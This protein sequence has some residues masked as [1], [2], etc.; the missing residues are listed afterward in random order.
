MVRAMAAA[1]VVDLLVAAM[2]A[3]AVAIA[4]V[5]VAAMPAAAARPSH[6]KTPAIHKAAANLQA[7]HATPMHKRR[8]SKVASHAMTSTTSSPPATRLPDSPLPANPPA[9]AATSVAAA[10]AAV[11]VALVAG[12]TGLVGRAVLARLLADKT[13]AAVHCVGRHPPAQQDPRRVA[14][15]VDS[16]SNFAAPPVDDVFIALGTT[17]KVAGSQPA[18]RAVDFDAVVAVA[19]AAK[20]AGATKLGVISAMGASTASAVFYNRVKGEMEDAID[21][22][23]YQALVIARPSMLAGDRD[24][25]AQA[26]RPAEKLGLLAMTLFKPLIPANYRAITATQVAHALLRAVQGTD[27]GTRVLL[28]GEMQQIR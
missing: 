17:I 23:G 14:H 4:V 3:K 16:F 12:A 28:S 21:Q 5:V 9:T 22:M 27:H 11:R 13:Y 18:F 20:A 7:S 10:P 25:L 2:V 19:R 24:A 26:T 1:A 6:G 15:L 8:V